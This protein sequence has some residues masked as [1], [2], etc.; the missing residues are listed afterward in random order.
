MTPERI[1]EIRKLTIPPADLRYTSGYVGN[2]LIKW[3]GYVQELVAAV[4]Q[5]TSVD[6]SLPAGWDYY[7]VTEEYLGGSSI[8]L[9]QFDTA[10]GIWLTAGIVTRWQPMPEL[11]G[12]S[13]QTGLE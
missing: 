8:N 9:V 3:S 11:P 12:T 4:P 10:K 5:W 7:L 6:D 2:L 13:P 1:A